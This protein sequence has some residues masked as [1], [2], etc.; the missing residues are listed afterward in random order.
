MFVWLVVAGLGSVCVACCGRFGQCLCGLLWQV[1]AVFVWLVV[2]G[3]GSVGVACY[4]RFGQCLYG[5]LW[6]V[7]AVF[8]WLVVAGLGLC[9]F[10]IVLNLEVLDSS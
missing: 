3:L 9:L 1:W 10:G 6:Q 5:L 8:V 4:G 7:W 2:A